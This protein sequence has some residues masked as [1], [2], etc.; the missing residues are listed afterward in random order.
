[1]LAQHQLSRYFT[2]SPSHNCRDLFLIYRYKSMQLKLVIMADTAFA[3][4]SSITLKPCL[5][6]STLGR[7]H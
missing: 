7:R 5:V 2:T 1:M 6:A 4:I 3:W